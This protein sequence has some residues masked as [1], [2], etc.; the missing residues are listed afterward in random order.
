MGVKNPRT[1]DPSPCGPDG[2]VSPRERDVRCLTGHHDPGDEKGAG[3][4]ADID[5]ARST[6]EHCVQYGDQRHDRNELEGND[7]PE[8]FRGDG[9]G[10]SHKEGRVLKHQEAH[11][12]CDQEDEVRG[13]FLDQALSASP[14]LSMKDC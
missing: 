6:E 2:L 5:C 4:R 9:Q 3:E 8:G 10:A 14:E 7:G 12:S 13:Q 1:L 11:E